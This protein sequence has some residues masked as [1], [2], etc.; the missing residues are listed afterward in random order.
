MHEQG[1]RRDHHLTCVYLPT[2]SR[3]VLLT[4]RVKARASGRS[5]SPMQRS[6][7]SYLDSVGKRLAFERSILTGTAPSRCSSEP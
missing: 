7:R 5:H 1:G 6:L 2:F 4:G 3:P